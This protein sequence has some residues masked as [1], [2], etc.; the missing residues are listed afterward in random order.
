MTPKPLDNQNKNTTHY[1]RK[2]MAYDKS[3]VYAMRQADVQLPDPAQG[4]PDPPPA[5]EFDA[6]ETYEEGYYIAIVKTADKADSWGCCFNCGEERSLMAAV[7]E[8]TQRIST[9]SKRAF[10]T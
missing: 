10:R 1:D 3:R 8:A 2:S 5:S 4:E 6:A 9:A 7:Y